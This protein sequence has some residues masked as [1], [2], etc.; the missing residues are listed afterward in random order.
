[1]LVSK[2]STSSRRL[3]ES[4][5][6]YLSKSFNVPWRTHPSWP[7]QRWSWAP[8][9]RSSSRL[10]RNCHRGNIREHQTLG[11][12]HRDFTEKVDPELTYRCVDIWNNRESIFELQSGDVSEQP[13]RF[14]HAHELHHLP[15][16]EPHKFHS[17]RRKFHQK[18]C[19]WPNSGRYHAGPLSKSWGCTAQRPK[20]RAGRNINIETPISIITSLVER[21]KK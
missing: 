18:Y 8:S 13:H 17:A 11:D 4:T 7:C 14:D 9:H 10:D 12:W 16:Y 20:I 5:G 19:A 21:Q 2:I 3:R 15:S 1:M 6:D